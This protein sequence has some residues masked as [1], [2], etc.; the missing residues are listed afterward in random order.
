MIIETESV[1]RDLS[2]NGHDGILHGV[3]KSIFSFEVDST[4]VAE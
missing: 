2:G 1:V 3:G 4:N